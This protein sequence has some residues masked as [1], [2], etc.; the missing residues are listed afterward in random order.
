MQRLKFRMQRVDTLSIAKFIVPDRGDKV[1]S[2]ILHVG[3]SYR[4]ARL[5]RLAGRYDNPMPGVNYIPPV[6]DY[7]FV[8]WSLE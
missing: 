8:Y 2:G 5:H 6:R 4:L 7:E 1:D 3:L